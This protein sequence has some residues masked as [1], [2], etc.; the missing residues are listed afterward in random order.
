VSLLRFRAARR[1]QS[2]EEEKDVLRTL[3]LRA[4]RIDVIISERPIKK[5]QHLNK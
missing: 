5:I 2:E 3:E 4:K 1:S